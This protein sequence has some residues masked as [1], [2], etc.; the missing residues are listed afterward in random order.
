MSAIAKDHPEQGIDELPVLPRWLH[1]FTVDQYH[2][3]AE[4]GVLTEND[5]VELIEGW[6]VD[7]M[8][9]D[10]PHDATISLLQAE[11]PPRLPPDRIVRI[12]S[13]ITTAES[14]P[15]PDVA[16]VKGPG[17]RYVRCHPRPR[18][19]GLVVEVADATL[20]YDRET[21][22][23]MYARARI[24]VYW[25]V[26]LIDSRIEVYTQPKG[27]KTPRYQQRH[28]YGIDDSVPVVIDGKECGRIPVRDLLP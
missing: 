6:I 28:D 19:I 10:P 1:Q 3:L 5:R 20:L 18:D 14:E 27:G 15:E 23:R 17:R 25:L 13:A 22:G 9:H 4:S 2:R 26:N 8:T 7:K 12:Q 24:P 21:K 11:L 16:V